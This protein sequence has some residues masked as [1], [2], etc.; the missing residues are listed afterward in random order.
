MTVLIAFIRTDD[1][2]LNYRLLNYDLLSGAQSVLTFSLVWHFSP[3]AEHS[4]PTHLAQQ[5]EGS[6][7]Y[8][9]GQL[10]L[11]IV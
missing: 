6:A 8:C 11:R 10:E 7:R 2:V 4:S 5:G 3:A 1:T 9:W